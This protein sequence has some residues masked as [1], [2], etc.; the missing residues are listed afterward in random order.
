MVVTPIEHGIELNRSAPGYVRSP[1]LH[2]SAI[3]SDLYAALEPKRYGGTDG[4]DPLRMELGL[5][6]EE[7][8]EESL[9]RRWGFERPGEFTTPEGIIFTPDLF[10]PEGDTFRVGEIKLTWMSSKGMPTDLANGFP[11]KFDKWMCQLMFYCEELGTDLGRLYA[12]FVNGNYAP[13]R[14]QLMAWDL[15]FSKRELQENR[16]MLINHAKH[17][18]LLS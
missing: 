4:P 5:A 16:T 1:G 7:G 13:S 8:L 10:I 6:L 9:R 12:F 11:P 3:Y 15:Q 2:A 14:P 18:G 17:T